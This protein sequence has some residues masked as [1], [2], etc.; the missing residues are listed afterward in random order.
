MIPLEKC[1]HFVEWTNKN[2]FFYNTQTGEWLFNNYGTW[3]RIAKST[4][5]LYFEVYIKEID[6]T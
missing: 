4:D 5:E 3:T 6:Q 1:Y 2:G